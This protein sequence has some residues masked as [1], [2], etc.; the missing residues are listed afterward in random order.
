MQKQLIQLQA[1]TPAAVVQGASDVRTAAR[2]L[3]QLLRLWI[4]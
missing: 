4:M 2:P 3:L 1:A